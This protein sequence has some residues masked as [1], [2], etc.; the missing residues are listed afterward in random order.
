MRLEALTRA[1]FFDAAA[2]R[3]PTVVGTLGTM[4]R[5]IDAYTVPGHGI[6]FTDKGK[7]LAVGGVAPL[8]DGVGE[9][10]LIPTKHMAGNQIALSRQFKRTIQRAFTDLKMRRVQAAVKVGFDK[11]HRLVRFLDMEEEG[12]MK[13]YGPEGADYVRYA[14]WL[15]Q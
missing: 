4:L 6:A 15:T 10:W 8:W 9:A 2:I 11:A 7:I 3:V 12:L 14:K 13:K 5:A 1:H